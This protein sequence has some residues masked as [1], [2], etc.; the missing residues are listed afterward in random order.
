VATDPGLR[1]RSVLRIGDG[2]RAVVWLGE[3][4]FET[5]ANREE[6]QTLARHATVF[7]VEPR[8]AGMQDEMHILRH[9]PIV[10][11]RPLVGMWGLAIRPLRF[12]AIRK[13]PMSNT[14]RGSSMNGWRTKRP[15]SSRNLFLMSNVL[16]G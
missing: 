9:A 13:S 7:V 6:V 3:S 2:P 14:S 4:D 11:G 12:H 10:M 5:E 15:E 8:G 1:A 16:V